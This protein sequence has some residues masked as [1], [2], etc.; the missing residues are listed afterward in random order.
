MAL[1]TWAYYIRCIF[2][3]CASVCL[4]ISVM[5]KRKSALNRTFSTESYRSWKRI[6]NFYWLENSR[7]HHPDPHWSVAPIFQ[8]YINISAYVLEKKE[9]ISDTCLSNIW[10]YISTR[11]RNDRILADIL[12]YIWKMAVS[13]QSDTI[14]DKPRYVT[15]TCGLHLKVWLTYRYSCRITFSDLEVIFH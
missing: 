3:L 13:D 2:R 8:I 15:S 10:Q 7:S 12:I 6:L 9:L 4:C 1:C 11:F 14:W 5:Q